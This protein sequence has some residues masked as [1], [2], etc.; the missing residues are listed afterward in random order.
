MILF[1]LSKVK[2]ASQINVNIIKKIECADY[3][4][5]ML[6]TG[7]TYDIYNNKKKVF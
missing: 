6:F 7:I 5:L 3:N 4:Q 2:T 1:N